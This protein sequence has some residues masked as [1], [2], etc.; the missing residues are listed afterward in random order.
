METIALRLYGKSDLRLERFDL[1]AM[2]DDE[3][4]AEIV[5]D[6]I[7]MSSHKAAI[8]GADHKRVPK[9]IAVHPVI[10][11]HEFAGT[12][13]A[14]GRKWQDRFKPG[15]RYTVQPAIVVP[16]RELEA[17]GYSFRYIGGSATKI[18]VPREVME[19]DCLLPYGGEGFFQ[20]SLSEPVSCIIG[21]F[22]TSY[23]FKQG[24][25]V[26]RMGIVAGG[27]T[28]ILA[29]AGPMGLG[30]IDYAVHGPRRPGVLAV[31]DI[32]PARLERA[33]SLFPP[34][35]AKRCGVDLRYVNTG[36][37]EPVEILQQ[38]NGGRLYDDVFVF[39]P[40]PA[41][42]EQASRLLAFNG[43]LNFFAG[44]SKQAFYASV[45]FYDIH[46]MGHHVV[47]SSG[48]NTDDMREAVDLMSKG[49]IN[50]A[51]MITHV[52]GLD[53]AAD[54]IMRLPSIPGSK[55][56][57]YNGISMPLTALDDFGKLGET[58]PFFARLAEI[59]SRHN[60][61]WS[62]EAENYLLKNA[63]SIETVVK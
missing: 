27:A 16:G 33:A 49:S 5:S 55:K 36:K 60:G 43:C 57:I 9:D 22:N 42:I 41:L 3:V 23:H 40:V 59:T 58:E 61:L 56:L 48:G 15:Q 26:H 47:G 28:A 19:M 10:I 7:C 20:A 37:G 25:Y 45:N 51:V 32:D 39:A 2:A 44:P 38:A 17:P 12:I 29:G 34:A 13:L 21:A 35:E 31:T 52:G 1:P 14:V 8:Q 63:R 62:V 53:C 30:A 54:S 24:E 6:S 11:G 18:I 46:Y 50:P 4:L